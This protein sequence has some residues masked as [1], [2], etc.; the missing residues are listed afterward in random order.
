MAKKT[1]AKKSRRRLKRTARRSLAA[2]LMITAVVVAAIPVPENVAAPEGGASAQA[3][4]EVKEPKAF[5]YMYGKEE[6]DLYD[7]DGKPLGAIKTYQEEFTGIEY[8]TPGDANSGKKTYSSWTV[9]E[10]SNG[11]WEYNWQ[12]EFFRAEDA[13]GSKAAVISKY[14]DTYSQKNVELNADIYYDYYKVTPADMNQFFSESDVP[15]YTGSIAHHGE[16][17]YKATSPKAP[18]ADVAFLSTYFKDDFNVFVETY[19]VEK[20]KYDEAYDAWLQDGQD[21]DKEPVPPTLSRKVSQMTLISDKMAYFWETVGSQIYDNWESYKLVDV[22]D[23]PNSGV[24]NVSVYIPRTIDGK[25]NSKTDMNGFLVKER[26]RLIGIGE[27]AFKNVTNVDTL[28]VPEEVV[29]IGSNAFEHSF[30]KEITLTSVKNISDRAFVDC[31]ELTKIDMGSQVEVIGTEAFR[32][33]NKLEE[34]T[35]RPFVRKIGPGAFSE[36]TSLKKVDFSRVSGGCTI[37]EYA[38]YNTLSLEN[39]NFGASQDSATGSTVNITT[40]GTGAFAASSTLKT[41]GFTS[42]TFPTYITSTYITNTTSDDLEPS[43]SVTGLGDCVLAGRGYLSEVTMSADFGNGPAARIPDYTFY[44]CYSLGKVVFPD[45]SG[46]C[47]RAWFGQWHDKTTYPSPDTDPVKLFATVTNPNF[48]VQGPKTVSPNSNEAAY[49]RQSTWKSAT[50]ATHYVPYL[51]IENGKKF[52]EISNGKYLMSVNEEGY[53]T[54]C[55][56]AP[57]TKGADWDGVLEIPSSVGDTTLKGIAGG[58]FHDDVKENAKEVRMEDGGAIAS[59]DA[60]VFQGWPELKKVYISN[61]VE[62]I[63]DYAFAQCPKLIDVTFGSSQG[64]H[65]VSIGTDSFKTE[66]SQLTFHGDIDKNYGPFQWAVNKDNIIKEPEGIRVCYKSLSPTFLTVMYDEN[67]DCV[68]LLD[69]PRADQIEK[70]LNEA[71]DSEIDGNYTDYLNMRM[72][73]SYE[74]YSADTYDTRREEFKQKWLEAGS[75][76]TA[77]ELVYASDIYGPWITPNFCNGAA[78]WTTASKES[79]SS[80]ILAG[81]NRVADFFF[82]PIVAYAADQPEPYYTRHPFKLGASDTAYPALTT[83]E[84]GL[85]DAVRHVDVPDGVDSIDVYGYYKDSERNKNNA[86]IYLEGK[87]D[88]AVWRAYTG[89]SGDKNDPTDVQPGLFSGYYVDYKPADSGR[90]QF[91]RGNDQIESIT[92][93]SVKSLPDY[94]FDS[95]E[96]LLEVDLGPACSDIGIAPFRGCYEMERVGDNQWYTTVNGIIYSNNTD[97]SKTIEECLAARGRKTNTVGPN[98]ISILSDENIKSVSAIKPGAFEDCDSLNTVLFGMDDTLG[99]K[100]I[101]E[102]CFRNCDNLQTVELPESVNDIGRGAFVGAKNLSRLTIYGDEVKISGSAFDTDKGTTTVRAHLDSAVARYVK[103]YGGEDQ[104]KLVLDETNPLGRRWKVTFVD[105]NNNTIENLADADGNVLENPM[106]IEDGHGIPSIP[107]DPKIDGWEFTGWAGTNGT[108]VNGNITQDTTFIMQ[109][110]RDT[111]GPVDGKYWV[112]FVDSMTGNVVYDLKYAEP[113]GKYYVTAGGTFESEGYEAP[114]HDVNVILSGKEPDGFSNVP[115]GD[116]NGMPW[117]VGTNIE[118]N[119]AVM[120]MYKDKT[121]GNISGGTTSGGTTSGG[122]TSGGTTSKGTTSKSSTSKKSSSSSSTSSSSTSTTSTTSAASMHRVTVV[123][124]SGSGIYAAGSTVVIAANEPA[125]GTRF[126]QWTT[127]S[128]GVTLNQ[129]T[130]TATIFTMPENDVLVTANYEQGTAPVSPTGTPAVVPG[131]NNGQTQ[132]NGNTRVDI[133]KPGISNRDLAT[134]NVSGSTD[135]F[136]VKISETD[137]ATRAVAAALT[138]KY[139][140]LDNI[141]YYAMD[142]NLYD[143]TGTTK[144][145][146]TTG[147]SVDITIPIPDSLVA[148]GGNN[149]AGAVI[150]GDQLE[151]LNEN[152]TTING[153]PCVRFRATHFSPYTI[154]VDTGNLV[155]GELDVTPKT[156]D[157]IHPKWFLSLGLACLSVILFL[158]RDKKVAVKA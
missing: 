21:P 42:F 10:K 40:L 76:S 35:F 102:D 128:P 48:Y 86:H 2:V 121:D 69:Y 53:L 6:K 89:L 106:Y 116:Q 104:Y 12:F 94:A 98:T 139:G 43:S 19:D 1:T 13:G 90:E 7:P 140:T 30:I 134:A 145:T 65:G 28:L 67:K 135:N 100:E 41:T 158:K 132:D 47:G 87:L 17:T 49:P 131:T 75:D 72:E 45:N 138:N 27:G 3:D 99:L 26:T 95:C 25:R 32:N 103:E 84:L 38:F 143:S 108:K 15:G 63:G 123:G 142:I 125:A 85:L 57:D 109:G 44:N 137:E 149:M 79:D 80:E 118:G 115:P 4:V 60:K 119:W 61:S 5:K 97:G 33:A 78:T 88:L 18:A 9:T 155:A 83:E 36:C 150:N 39:V 14:N 68:T 73:K 81:V 152:F 111:S 136:V 130:A 151:S 29:Y 46:S 129:M 133:E 70:I 54:S 101:P 120:L 92:L 31:G 146:D 113:D 147:L 51:Y 153:I 59:I 52:Y 112:M 114:Q 127:N 144:I 62:M 77:Q 64:A 20:K 50:A 157:P 22:I 71:H 55:E 107:A 11:A 124:G 117:T 156:G 96:N 23:V 66:S 8:N 58:C 93:H 37:G 154:Y 34:V 122:T 56:L 126:T 105:P 91:G 148:Y 82:E 24:T 141:L 74:E 16:T 110:N